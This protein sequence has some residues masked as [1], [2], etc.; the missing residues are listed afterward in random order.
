MVTGRVPLAVAAVPV[1]TEIVDAVFG[2]VD[3]DGRDE[4]ILVTR[5]DAGAAP[6]KVRLVIVR[7]DAAGAPLPSWT[8]DLGNRPALW[9]AGGGLW[10]VDAQGLARVEP[11]TG[12]QT[13]LASFASP[14]AALGPTSP[15]HADLAWDL[16]GDTHPELVTWSAGRWLAFRRTGAAFGA[17]GGTGTGALSVGWEQGGQAVG[18]TVAIPPLVV[19]DVDGDGRLDLAFPR[20]DRLT[21]YYTGAALGARAAELRLPL[22]LDPP[23]RAPRPGETR[24]EVS[25]VWFQDLDG[26]GKI[27]LAVQRLVFSGSWFGSTTE[28]VWARGTGA[29]FGPLATT[30]VAATAFSVEPRDVDGDGDLD[31]VAALLD[32]GVANLARMLVQ[33]QARVDLTLFRF[34]GGAY[35]APAAL[36]TVTFPIE[37]ADAFHVDATGDVDGDR[38]L[39]LVIDEGQGVRVYR[40]TA[41][42]LEAAPAHTSTVVV[43]PG[44]DNLLVHDLTGDG[45]AEIVVWGR[46][47]GRV[48]ILR[49]P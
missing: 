38:R 28:V 45:R 26:D 16:D 37:T 21:V 29:G 14:L 36:R 27:D 40:G 25:G 44:D 48:Q 41:T 1:P 43:P 3:A 42:G 20:G 15:R 32:T 35:A 10:V 19:G 4:L 34:G 49:V 39:D 13:R 6:P 23:E 33:K 5:L 31:I 11:S 8:V 30:P 9:D 17:V 24:R 18:A 12:A 46:D 47:A 22:D 2:D 7:M